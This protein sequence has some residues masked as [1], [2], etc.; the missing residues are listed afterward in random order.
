MQSFCWCGVV[1]LSWGGWRGSAASLILFFSRRWVS[2]LLNSLRPASHARDC[3]VPPSLVCRQRW[4]G[5]ASRLPLPPAYHLVSEKGR[6]MVWILPWNLFATPV[7][8][9]CNSSYA[10]YTCSWKACLGHLWQT[11]AYFQLPVLWISSILGSSSSS[12][13]GARWE[14]PASSS[15]TQGCPLEFGAVFLYRGSGKNNWSGISHGIRVT[16][17]RSSDH[18]C[19]VTWHRSSNCSDWGSR[20]S[21]WLVGRRF[22]DQININFR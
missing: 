11:P 1:G 3:C 8:C 6:V 10:Y 21:G 17:H 12:K 14:L 18:Q 5:F 9:S 19:Q 7:S 15:A 2:C 13:E 22:L 16:W 20:A 4:P